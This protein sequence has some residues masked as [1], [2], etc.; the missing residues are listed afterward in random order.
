MRD[1]CEIVKR[2]YGAQILA[3]TKECWLIGGEGGI[4]VYFFTCL[5]FFL[6]IPREGRRDREGWR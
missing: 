3:I 5:Y 2:Y 6:K 1:L 4:Y